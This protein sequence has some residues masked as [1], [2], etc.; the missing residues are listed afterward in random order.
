[1]R[2]P[3]FGEQGAHPPQLQ[4]KAAPPPGRGRFFQDNSCE[5]QT[6]SLSLPAEAITVPIPI[7][8]EVPAPVVPVVIAIHKA[9]PIAVPSKAPAPRHPIAAII[10]AS[11]PKVPWPRARRDVALMHAH[12]NAK[13]G[14]LCR[15][16]S[17]ACCA[18]HYNRSQHPI[19][20]AAHNPSILAGIR[21]A[22][23]RSVAGPALFRSEAC[24]LLPPRSRR[25]C[26]VQTLPTQKVAARTRK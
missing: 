22:I 15:N 11:C 4:Q 14:S 1:M 10:V 21:L 2:Q 17:Q 16:A 23:P 8:I 3:A 24:L 5:S 18:C 9:V 26:P 6:E 13:L 25:L 20:H 7:P 12:V 19:L